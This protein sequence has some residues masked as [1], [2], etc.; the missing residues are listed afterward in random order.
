LRTDSFGNY[1][2]SHVLEC[3][4]LEDRCKII[5]EI[6]DDLVELS[7]TKN[8]SNVVETCLN[9]APQDRK[10]QIIDHLVSVPLTSPSCAT[11]SDLMQSK[12]GNFVVQRVYAIA[13]QSR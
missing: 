2:V 11:I 6:M 12:F 10:T 4:D 3:G 5:D 8:G 7:L 13:D 9:H 1:V